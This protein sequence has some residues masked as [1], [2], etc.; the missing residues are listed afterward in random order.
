MQRKAKHCTSPPGSA[1]LSCTPPA[2]CRR[3]APPPQSHLI[4]DLL[5]LFSASAFGG[6][7][8]SAAHIYCTAP[9]SW[10]GTRQQHRHVPHPSVPSPRCMGC[11]L[12]SNNINAP[13]GAELIMCCCWIVESW[14]R[15]ETCGCWAPR[16]VVSLVET[17]AIVR[18]L[19]RPASMSRCAMPSRDLV[20]APFFLARANC[21][22]LLAPAR[23]GFCEFAAGSKL[24]RATQA[25]PVQRNVSR[26]QR[27]MTVQQSALHCTRQRCC[28]L[29][30]GVGG[31]GLAPPS[32]QDRLGVTWR[33]LG[34]IPALVNARV[35]DPLG[36]HASRQKALMSRCGS[37]AEAWQGGQGNVLAM[38]KATSLAHLTQAAGCSLNLPQTL[39]RQTAGVQ[40]LL[41]YFVPG[42]HNGKRLVR[43]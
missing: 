23:A 22:L 41:S 17:A 27:S 31:R 28:C 26:A 21:A 36:K 34:R 3:V 30:T 16:F 33:R 40:P 10:G 15:L 35:C 25:E 39:Q 43:V 1:I 12:R 14:P 13:C 32:E 29:P 37:P 4:A 5:R 38:R 2:L 20:P 24:S 18:L 11:A 42:V 7:S 6:I 8:V 19:W 9:A